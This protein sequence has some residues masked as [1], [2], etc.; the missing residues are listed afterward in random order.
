MALALLFGVL[1]VLAIDYWRYYRR[2]VP[3]LLYHYFTDQV[4]T[5]EHEVSLEAFSSQLRMLRRLGFSVL[6]LENSLRQ[7]SRTRRAIAITADDGDTSVFSKALPILEKLAIPL[8]AFVVVDYSDKGVFQSGEQHRT[9]ASWDEIRAWMSRYPGLE[10][11]L[12]SWTHRPLPGCNDSELTREIAEA[13]YGI[14]DSRVSAY[15]RAAG[16]AAACATTLGDARGRDAFLVEREP[17]HADTTTAQFLIKVLG[18]RSYVRNFPGVRQ[19]RQRQWRRAAMLEEQRSPGA[20][21]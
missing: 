7:G 8:T 17:I 9:A 12:H 1:A 15:A 11:G 14:W 16:Y 18:V 4:P 21:A 10:I 2:F 19:L 5:C 6:P 13:A 3:V 20:G